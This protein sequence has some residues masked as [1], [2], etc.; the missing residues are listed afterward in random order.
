M[1]QALDKNLR[2]ALERT[3]VNARDVAEQ[4]VREAITRLGVA[5]PQAPSYLDDAEKQLRVKLRAHARQLGDMKYANDTQDVD[6]LIAEAAY[7][8]WH[9]MLFARF[10]E[11]NN[12]LMFDAVTSLTLDECAELANEE[13][14]A[15]PWAYAAQLASK[16]LPQ[17]FRQDSPIFQLNLALEHIRD[18]EVKIASIAAETFQAQDALGW[19]YQFW[20]TKRKQD[21]N[22]SGVKIGAKELSPVTQL[23]TEP[24]MVSFL[25]D[26][27]L[28]AWWANK[29][30]SAN[31]IATAKTEQDLR[32]RAALPGVP[33][34][35]LRFVANTK[36]GE[37]AWQP[38]AGKFEQ[39][40]QHLSELKTL[41]PC[42]GSGHFLVAT[43]LMLVP[44]RMALENL[45]AKE[46]VDA[47]LRQNIHGLELDQ[48]C[49]ELAAFALA[50]EAW[51][52]PNAGGYRA[53]PELHIACAG[54]S[55]KAAKAEWKA[56][57][58]QL[59]D[60]GGKKNLAIALDWL[61]QTFAD[62]PVLGSLINP[63][64]SD[65]AKIVRW[66]E[67]S[68]ALNQA[69]SLNADGHNEERLEAGIIAQGLAKAATLLAGEYS[70][71]ITNVPYLARGKQ[72]EVLK[73]FCEAHY[74]EAKNDLATVFLD[75]CLELCHQGGTACIVLPQN[76]LFLTSYKKFREKLLRQDTW[77]MLARLGEGGFESSAAA[78]AFVALIS[79]SRG[80]KR[81][82]S[83]SV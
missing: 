17:V 77:N 32:E 67:L 14:V 19:V 16:M 53:L 10:L 39:W 27:A 79:I 75:R 18:L 68:A 21:V 5:E 30:L 65:A 58:I 57:G 24:Y 37:P 4:A 61:H 81:E 45:S 66:E 62:A 52:Y 71:V 63:R 23:F 22:D 69:L 72:D 50:L 43:F 76:W 36:E 41:D 46:A 9:R 80:Q 29:R 59:E 28:G 82:Q 78:G 40:P 35:Y 20:Q 60:A 8:H 64:K 74:P 1:R 83:G 49:V 54:L 12:L 7:E 44:M 48:R 34:S 70:W 26:N 13:G 3:V 33:L 73:D 38:A 6:L 51:R 31:D 55:V 56:L 47:V 15:S 25:L 2:N 11:Q 42:C